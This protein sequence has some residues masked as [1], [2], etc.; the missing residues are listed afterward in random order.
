MRYDLDIAGVIAAR[1]HVIVTRQSI[2]EYFVKLSISLA[3]LGESEVR[4]RVSIIIDALRVATLGDGFFIGFL[5]GFVD[6]LCLH[7]ISGIFDHAVAQAA[8]RVDGAA[9]DDIQV[10]DHRT[11]MD[12]RE[13]TR[14]ILVVGADVTRL[15]G[16]RLESLRGTILVILVLFEVVSELAPCGKGDR[17]SLAVKAAVEVLDDGSARTHEDIIAELHLQPRESGSRRSA[18][19]HQE[20]AVIVLGLRLTDILIDAEIDLI[21]VLRE[22][23]EF[24]RGVDHRIDKDRIVEIGRAVRQRPFSLLIAI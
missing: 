4:H 12:H 11:L 18:E 22:L 23:S 3:V 10:L 24:A 13:E 2:E 7:L 8:A 17:K 15:I 19:T 16:V 21:D 1:R 20:I 6:L 5:V 14:R 9:E